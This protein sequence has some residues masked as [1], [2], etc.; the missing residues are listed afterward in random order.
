VRGYKLTL[1]NGKKLVIR[2]NKKSITFYDVYGFFRKSLKIA[3]KTWLGKNVD[4]LDKD[5]F[6][7]IKH[8]TKLEALQE[9]ANLETQY[10]TELASKLNN[11]LTENNINLSS[12]HGASAVSSWFLHKTKAKDEFYNYK[13]KYQL[14]PELYKAH[15]QAYYGGRVEQ[16]KIGTLKNVNVYDINS[17]YA[18]ASLLLPQFLR[19]PTFTRNYKP[20]EIFSLWFCEYNFKNND[21][22]LGLLSYRNKI[23]NSITYRLQGKGFYYQPEIEFILKHYPKR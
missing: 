17:A 13:H 7:Q 1:A 22:Y 12:Y 9:Y 19:K 16:F 18:S 2:K 6:L 20:N 5:V 10:I 15:R 8:L 23:G 14:S 21:I 4:I 3:V 11:S